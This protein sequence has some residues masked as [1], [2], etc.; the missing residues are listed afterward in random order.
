MTKQH[1]R[2][3]QSHDWYRGYREIGNLITPEY[4]IQVSDGTLIWFRDYQELRDWA[5]Y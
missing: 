2:W 3:A 5:G 1:V 4:E